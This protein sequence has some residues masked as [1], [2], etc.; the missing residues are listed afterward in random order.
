M[1]TSSTASTML[2]GPDAKRS[3]PQ[4]H[5]QPSLTSHAL[6][7]VS[8]FKARN[9]AAKAR[10]ET[11]RAIPS[12]S[13]LIFLSTRTRT[14][15]PPTPTHH[16]RTRARTFAANYDPHEPPTATKH[17]LSTTKARQHRQQHARAHAPILNE[18]RYA[19]DVT[20]TLSQ[21]WPR[22]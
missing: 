5:G 11:Q 13:R 18:R 8:D 2:D 20:T 22:E 15:P 6:L 1:R 7:R 10:F 17:T 21:T 12:Q 9:A 3:H 14:P 16:S 19:T 4:P